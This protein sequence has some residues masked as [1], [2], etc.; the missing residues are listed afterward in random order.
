M[1][2]TTILVLFGGGAAGIWLGLVEDREWA[3]MLGLVAWTAAVL[4]TFSGGFSRPW[5]AIY[6]TRTATG[7]D[8]EVSTTGRSRGVATTGRKPR[9]GDETF[10]FLA[11]VLVGFFAGAAAIWFGLVEDMEWA[12]PLGLLFW[13]G[14]SLVTFTGKI[15][16]IRF[17]SGGGAARG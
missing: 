13:L 2:T 10:G 11:V 6:K 15:P 14:A 9:A 7:R 3:I 12:F 8:R 17:S 4:A 5:P 16:R 1:H